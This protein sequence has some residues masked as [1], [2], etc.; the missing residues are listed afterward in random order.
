VTGLGID[1][2]K[3]P[4]MVQTLPAADFSRDY[5]PNVV[6][7]FAQ[8]IPGVTT[9]NVQGNE[10]ATDLRYIHRGT[11]DEDE[12]LERSW[13]WT[14][15]LSHVASAAYSSLTSTSRRK[16]ERR[17]DLRHSSRHGLINVRFRS[18]GI[19]PV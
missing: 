6:E 10:F 2:D 13:H 5:S 3:V 1:R 4:A 9:N 15:F 12:R 14:S 7:T 8:R 16:Q 18:C 17:C 19:C 11:E